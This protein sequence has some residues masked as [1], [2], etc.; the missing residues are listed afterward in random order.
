MSPKSKNLTVIEKSNNV[1]DKNQLKKG[2]T[3][4]EAKPSLKMSKN[5]LK[6]YPK[7]L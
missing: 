6:L 7:L 2:E 3:F 4:T 1:L 5:L